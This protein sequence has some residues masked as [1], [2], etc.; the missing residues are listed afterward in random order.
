M[1]GLDVWVCDVKRDWK[2]G[3]KATEKKNKKGEQKMGEGCVN[4]QSAWACVK[5]NM[6]DGL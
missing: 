3:R 6:W 5:T 1:K 4:K 2:R